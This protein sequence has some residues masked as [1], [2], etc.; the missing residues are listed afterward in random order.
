MCGARRNFCN[1]IDLVQILVYIQLYF[2]QCITSSTQDYSRYSVENLKRFPAL[3]LILYKIY[4]AYY[5]FIFRKYKRYEN[6]AEQKIDFQY[7]LAN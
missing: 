3:A 6:G 5:I 2:I 1:K 7:D 4:H